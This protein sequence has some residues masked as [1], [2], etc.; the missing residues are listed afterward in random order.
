MLILRLL[1]KIKLYI[2]MINY[3]M[4]NY[5]SEP[6]RLYG[7]GDYAFTNVKEVEGTEDFLQLDED[8]KKCQDKESVVD[9]LSREYLESGRKKCGCVPYELRNYSRTVSFYALI[10]LVSLVFMYLSN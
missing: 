1:Y 10:S 9:C 6:L 2:K 3:E 8:V 4:K 5:F 7:A